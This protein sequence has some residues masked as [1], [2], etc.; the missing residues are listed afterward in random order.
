MNR[1]CK[2]PAERWQHDIQFASS[3]HMAGEVENY[4]RPYGPKQF[5]YLGAV[6][7]VGLPPTKMLAVRALRSS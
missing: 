7:A 6:S 2:I 4:L 5:S 3:G 1:A